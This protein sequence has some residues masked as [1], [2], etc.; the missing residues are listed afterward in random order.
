M[1]PPVDYPVTDE[2]AIGKNLSDIT[3]AALLERH[4]AKKSI[5]DAMIHSACMS[6]EAAQQL[7]S[8]TKP[9]IIAQESAAPMFK[10]LLEVIR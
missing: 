7:E 2:D 3:Y 8:A 6:M 4:D 9:K 5:T 1:Y 10:R